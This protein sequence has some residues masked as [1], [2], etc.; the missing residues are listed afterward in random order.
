MGSEMCIRDRLAGNGEVPVY[1]AER[2]AQNGISV[3]SISFSDE[4]NEKLKPLVD[5]SYSISLGFLSTI[6]FPLCIQITKV[7]KCRLYS[8]NDR[9]KFNF[10]F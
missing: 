2:A 1:F 5:K 10:F 6:L 9:C 7:S 4:I 8:T 3:V